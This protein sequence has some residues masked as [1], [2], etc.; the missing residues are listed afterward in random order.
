MGFDM[1]KAFCGRLCAVFRELRSHAPFTILGAALG[2]IFMVIFRMITKSPAHA[3]VLF[4]IAHPAHVVL[5]AMVTA[6]LFAIYR[7]TRHFLVLLVV[8]WVGA[9]GV[10]TLSDSII[11]FFGE[12]VLGVAIP[13]HAHMHTHDSH[14]HQAQT[15]HDHDHDHNHDH[16][17][18]AHEH[19]EH[20]HTAHDHTSH[21][22]SGKPELHLGFIE[23]WYI[24]NPAA[25]IGILIAWKMPHTKFP[26][27]AHVLISTWASSAH[28]M[29]NMHAQLTFVTSLGI[30]IVLFL[31]VWLPCCISDIVFPMLLV[32]GDVKKLNN[33][34]GQNIKDND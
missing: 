15:P 34:H 10:A 7:G 31:A 8:G 9:I 6:S 14:E 24:V 19:L 5:S 11:P 33:H 16:E 23:H 18:H 27:A 4:G 21:Q 20:D 28:I 29:M 13:T 3:E 22:H 32:K 25:L 1:L 12:S 30:F 26:H 17:A 2:V